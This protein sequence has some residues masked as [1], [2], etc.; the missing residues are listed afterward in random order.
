MIDELKK[1]ASQK[2]TKSMESLSN[3]LSKIRTGRAHPSILDAITVEYYGQEVPL[4]QV[5]NIKIEDAKTLQ[6]NVWEK[7]MIKEVE[8]S[9]ISSDL[10]LNPA[11]SGNLIRIPL[12]PL[13]EER[14]KELVKLVKQEGENCKVSVRNIRRDANNKLKQLLKEKSISEDDEKRSEEDIQK[15]TDSNIKQIDERIIE[16]EKDLMQI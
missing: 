6:L 9:I 16:K 11:V 2:M 7:N 4:N 10:G 14:R 8:K 13:T 15:L 5:A 12:P 3:N 1:E